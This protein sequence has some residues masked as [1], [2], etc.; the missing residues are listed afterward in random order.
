MGGEVEAAEFQE[1]AMMA[2]PAKVS[3]LGWT[4]R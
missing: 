2:E 1:L 4:A 3:S